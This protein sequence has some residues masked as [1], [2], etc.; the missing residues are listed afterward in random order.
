[1][2]TPPITK[3]RHNRIDLAVHT[4]REGTGRNL[5]LLHGLGEHSATAVPAEAADWPG[6]VYALDFTGHGASDVPK[7][8]GYSAEILLGDTDVTLAEIGP[9]T[10]VGRGLGAY[11]A[12]L[13]AGARPSLVRGAVLGDGPGLWGGPSG[14]TSSSVVVLEPTASTPDPYALYEMSRD[15]RPR[16]YAA[17][18]ARL[19]V[20]HSGLA[21]PITVT[22]FIRP[23]WLDA[24]VDEVGVAEG[25]LA[26]ALATYARV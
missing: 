1:M 4:L 12:L 5:L 7:G 22:A 9:A 20:E 25:T 11:V 10:V 8:G 18:F 19:A 2:S 26:S 16:D 15:L 3:L 21:E 24:V 23:P 17:L 14:P 13:L 6:P